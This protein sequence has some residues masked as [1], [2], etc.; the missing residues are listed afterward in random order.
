[1]TPLRRIFVSIAAG[2]ILYALILA[3]TLRFPAVFVKAPMLVWNLRLF[4][5][6]GRGEAV[7]R[8]PNGEPIYDGMEGFLGVA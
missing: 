7:G 3:I 1:M 6:L 4:S 2:D 8:M 5:F